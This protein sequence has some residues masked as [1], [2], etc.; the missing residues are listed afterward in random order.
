VRDNISLIFLLCS[1]LHQPIWARAHSNKFTGRLT[2]LAGPK[3]RQYDGLK[4]ALSALS[5]PRQN[6]CQVMSN[7][8]GLISNFSR[9]FLG[10]FGATLVFGLCG[11]KFCKTRNT[12]EL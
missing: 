12:S 1:I 11:I 6:L 9:V 3:R 5:K 7:D 2:D 4:I 8:L 10:Y